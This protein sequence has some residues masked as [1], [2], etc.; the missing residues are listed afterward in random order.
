VVLQ[1]VRQSTSEKAYLHKWILVC[2]A[3]EDTGQDIEVIVKRSW[4]VWKKKMGLGRVKA[5]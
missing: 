4:R 5:P 3:V 2:L 1:L